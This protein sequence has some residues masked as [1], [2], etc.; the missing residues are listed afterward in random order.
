MNKNELIVMIGLPSSGKSTY[1]NKRFLKT[2][3]V[4]CADD[5]RLALGTEFNSK[6]EPFVHAITQ[7][8]CRA[9]MERSLDIVID[10]TNVKQEY[11]KIWL[12][13]VRDYD[14]ETKA[15]VLKTPSYKC[16]LRKEISNPEFSISII[17]TMG[18]QLVDL[19]TD[20]L[21]EIM[22]DK[23]IYVIGEEENE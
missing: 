13:I 17:H 12:D 18:M 14:Y 20:G 1:V 23:V 9:A 8:M 4:I 5:I 10:S 2:H 16:I 22:Y 3:Q 21:L 7:T 19:L 11:N 15:I 6:T